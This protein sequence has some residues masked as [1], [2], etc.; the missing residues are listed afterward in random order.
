[1]YALGFVLATG[2]VAGLA[3]GL[4]FGLLVALV[5]GLVGVVYLG[6]TRR[7]EA[8]GSSLTPADVW[9]QDRN[10]ALSGWLVFA[11]VGW[12]VDRLVPGLASELV[13]VVRSGLV[14][15]FLFALVLVFLFERMVE[16]R[17]GAQSWWGSATFDAAWA[18]VQL[19]IRYKIPLRLIT[20]LEDA[21]SRHLL[22]TVGPVYQFRHRTL[23]ARLAAYPEDLPAS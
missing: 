4:A 11:L 2:L 18:L 8:N 16:R 12:L 23:Q 7:T 3:S 10:D 15:V 19:A 9:R 17:R 14:L 1:L 20:F 13:F 6:L 22:R 5:V 21:R